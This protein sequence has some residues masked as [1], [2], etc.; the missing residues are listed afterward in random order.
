[1]NLLD[2]GLYKKR[3]PGENAARKCLFFC[4]LFSLLEL[5]CLRT[6]NTDKHHNF[7]LTIDLV[8][9]YSGGVLSMDIPTSP[10][11]KTLIKYL[12][13]RISWIGKM[14][15]VKLLKV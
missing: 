7:T 13:V 9:P 8:H 12:P 3:D 14:N 15:Y 6:C 2:S 1:M 11:S 10:S 4:G 5:R